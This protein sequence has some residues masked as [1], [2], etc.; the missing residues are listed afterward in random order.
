M[1]ELVAFYESSPLELK[2]K[3]EESIAWRESTTPIGPVPR[4][5]KRAQTPPHGLRVPR[6]GTHHDGED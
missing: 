1:S 2:G 5:P 3:V 6:A 4:P